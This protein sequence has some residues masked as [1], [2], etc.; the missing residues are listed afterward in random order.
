MLQPLLAALGLPPHRDQAAPSQAAGT[1]RAFAHQLTTRA[2]AATI[3]A[4]WMDVGGWGDWDLGLQRAVAAG[5]LSLGAKGMIIDLAGRKAAFQVSEFVPGV[6]YAFDTR[7][8]GARLRVRRLLIGQH[9]TQFR[10]EVSLHGP[11]AR[12]WAGLLGPNF[13]TALPPTMAR[14]AAKA[15]EFVR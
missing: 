15:E 2:P 5:P 12:L 8:P 11:A 13:R 9:P 4:L 10:H 14:L 7:L 6:R 1:N 3:W